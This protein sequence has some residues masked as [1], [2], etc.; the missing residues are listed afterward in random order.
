MNNKDKY[1]TANGKWGDFESEYYIM[2]N[3]V[4]RLKEL[5]ENR[6]GNLCK[7]SKM[8]GFHKTYLTKQLSSLCACPRAMT[9]DKICKHLDTSINYVILGFG[10][11][12]YTDCSGTFN[13]FIRLYREK[14]S[15]K[16]H[17][18]LDVA[19]CALIK[20]AIKNLPMKFLIRVAREQHVTI[21]WLIGG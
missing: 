13:N 17:R 3:A 1:Y 20:G 10:E 2:L 9:V 11:Q 4:D 8:L 21:D 15:G 7:A 14:Y 18:S 16:H 5:L 12:Q 19:V 6:Y